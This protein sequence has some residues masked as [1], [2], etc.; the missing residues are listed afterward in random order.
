MLNI[1]TKQIFNEG[2]VQFEEHLE[3]VELG[4]EKYAKIPSCSAHY[5]DDE[6]GSDG[7]NIADMIYDISDKNI[8]GS[9]S[10][11]EVQ[12]HLPTWAKK[13][14]SCVRENIGKP[15]DLRRTRSYFQRAG[16]ALSC[17]DSLLYKTYYLMIGSDPKYYYHARKY[18]IWQAA[19]DEEFNS[20]RKN[21]TWELVS[22]PPGRK[23]V[24]CKWVFQKKK[25]YDGTN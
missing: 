10:D 1:R 12:T 5:L 25:N 23:L 16:I 2:S 22:L 21:A 4:K 6:I 3:E 11:S 7:S 17:H 24:Q 9:E 15:A 13:T 19:M 14:L 8:S 18:S 20:L